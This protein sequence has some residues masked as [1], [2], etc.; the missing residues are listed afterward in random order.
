QDQ[1]VVFVDRADIDRTGLS[2]AAEVLQRL[3]GSGGAL[4]SRFNNSGNFGNPP[5]GGGVGAGAAE[6]DLRYLGSRRVLVLV[7]GLRYV[8][9]ASASGIPG[10]VDLN[11]IPEAM[12]ERI[13]VLQGGASAIYGS[14]A[15]SGVINFIT[16][17]NFDGLKLVAQA[18]IS[19]Y[20]DAGSWR[21]G[22]A[23]GTE[24]FGGRG[25]FEASYEYRNDSGLLYRSDRDWNNQWSIGGAG[26]TAS[27][28]RL[29]NNVRLAT[30]SFGGLIT[31][32]VLNGQ[33]F[34]TD[35]VLTPFVH[36]TSTGVACC[37]IG[38]DGA[39]YDASLK[40]PLAS[41]QLFGRF[42]FEV[43]D[44]IHFYAVGS[45]NFKH[46][47][48]FIDPPS[49]VN[50]TMS[51]AN[52]LLAQQYRTQLSNAGQPTFRMSELM[53]Q[54]SPRTNPQTDS[55]Q[56][57][58]NVGFDGKF[59]DFA[60]G[61]SYI[62]GANRQTNT[63]H[64]NLNRDRL[65]AALDA[66]SSGGQIVCNVT[67]T[68]PGLYPG[69]IPLNIFGP[70]ASNPAAVAWILGDTQ[71]VAR[72]RTDDFEA[73]IS[74]SIFNNWAGPVTVAL[75]G[76]W[77]KLTYSQTSTAPG[78]LLSNCTGLRF[79]CVAT[80]TQWTSTSS[81]RSTVSQTVKEGAAEIDFP[82]LKDVPFFQAL[83]VNGAARF[84]SYDISGNYWTWKVGL[85]WHVS[86]SIRF[87][88][89]RSRDIRAPTLDDLYAPGGSGQITNI[90]LLTG[91]N[92]QVPLLTGGNPNLTAEIGSTTTAGVVIKPAFLPGFSLAV[93]FYDIRIDNAISS[94]LGY[95]ATIQR[96]CYDSG[97]TSPYC[98]LQTRPGSFTDTSPANAVTSWR[99]TVINIAQAKTHGIDV[100][101]N[102]AGEVFGR[103][104]ALR[105]LVT[106]QPKLTFITPGL[107]TLEH[108]GVAF[109]TNALYPTP[110]WRVSLFVNI[111]PV[112][113]L[114]IN[115]LEKWRSSYTM[116]D[117][118][119]HVWIDPHVDAIAYTNINVAFDI[120][121]GG[122]K[123]Q[124][125]FNVQNLFNTDPPPA[126]FYGTQTVP[127]RMGGWAIGDDPIGRYF[128]GGVR[129]KF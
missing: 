60:W 26:T 87:R 32:G 17:R 123:F 78:T 12:I 35:G 97:G 114:T 112:D 71:S 30:T 16:D 99:N 1:P 83:N 91:L 110:K 67:V 62:H 113:G 69:C 13:E 8:N 73:S 107:T 9:G 70:T 29:V 4:N 126:A 125:F 50:V 75:S 108:A 27:P 119:A 103:P 68:N 93:D 21:A 11:S 127:G 109:A 76:E 81:P 38:G 56:L 33:N 84:T 31:S 92:P 72:T 101:A 19:D 122:A 54:N 14:D 82:V 89:T 124:L 85:D 121:G 52:P 64:N 100:E 61:V 86:D 43:T 34:R 111:K 22:G 79:N 118:P 39:Y 10:S 49:L 46:N 117:D 116:K 95:N 80:A 23:F 77:R 58:F 48:Q 47:E 66:V 53:Y 115:I 98:A 105:G 42:D 102:W 25:H 59:G 5:D 24:L 129:I 44:D 41:H 6:V 2:S 106:Y 128:T 15:I 104:F 120:D 90:D 20:G 18:G 94:Q 96:A 63:I 55:R 51:S 40:A 3:P 65:S 74:G 45:A 88:A 36:G 28:Y 7:D 37:E 57:F